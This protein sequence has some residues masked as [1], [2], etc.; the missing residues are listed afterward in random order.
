[1]KDEKIIVK[2]D[3]EGAEYEILDNLFES[4]V[5]DQIDV[6]LLEWHDKG[7]EEIEKLLLESGFNLFIR[8]LDP[9]SGM[10]YAYKN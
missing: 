6:L 9:I 4:G 10:V 8:D 3:C 2:M 5:I 7:V 1:V